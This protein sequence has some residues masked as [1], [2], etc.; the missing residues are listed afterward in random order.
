MSCFRPYIHV[1]RDKGGVSDGRNLGSGKRKTKFA[2]D[3]SIC[4]Q[5]TALTRTEVWL[6]V[7]I[8]NNSNNNHNGSCK[9]RGFVFMWNSVPNRNEIYK[10][11]K[12]NVS[13]RIN[14]GRQHRHSNT[15]I[16]I[17][18]GGDGEGGAESKC[19]NTLERN[20]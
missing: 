8:G 15:F 19:N 3:F 7:H 5:L 13:N 18:C 12:K 17:C 4:R 10:I 9:T 16:T 1:Y 2:K 14:N 20:E 6:R 11:G